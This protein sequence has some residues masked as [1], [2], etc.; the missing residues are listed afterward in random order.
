VILLTAL[1]TEPASARPDR[2]SEAETLYQRALAADLASVDG[3]RQA[4]LELEQAVLLAPDRADIQ[5]TLARLNYRMGFLKQARQRFQRVETLEPRNADARIGLGLV[6]RRDYLKYLDRGSLARA[7]E[8]FAAAAR[9]DS[10][11]CDPWLHLVPLY[12]EQANVRASL[13]VAERAHRADASRADALLGLAHAAFRN[14]QVERADSAFRRALP[15]LP[16]EVRER[17]DDIA[18]VSSEADT[19]TL[20]RLPESEQGEFVR[21]FWRE[22]DPDL[23]TTENEAQLEYW[24]RVTQAYFLFYDGRRREWDQRGEVYVRYGPPQK[25]I[26]NPVGTR[27]NFSF[28]GGPDFPMNVL[29]W[30]YPQ[31]GMN[32]SMQDRLLTEHYLRPISLV[33]DTDP[34]PD[35]DSLA[36]HQ[37]ALA[38]RGG[39]GVFPM[40]PPGARA[41]PIEGVIARFEGESGPRLM[42]LMEAPGSPGDTLWGSLVVLDSTLH[43]VARLERGLSPSLCDPAKLRVADFLTELPPGSYL[44]GLSVRDASGRRGL[45]RES[46]RLDPPRSS[47]ALSD[48]VVSCGGPQVQ[49]GDEGQPPSIRLMANPA[50]RVSGVDPLTVYFEMYHLTLAA[51][52]LAR[53]EFEYTVRS[54]ERD[55]R[56]WIQ[57]VL[58]P[59]RALPNVSA[60]RREEQAGTMRRQ[61]V[62]VPVHD[63]P[64]GRYVLEIQV[65]DLVAGTE[66]MRVASFQK[67]GG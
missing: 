19:A 47:L 6:W 3:R 57:R 41:L 25:A 11:R 7:I 64:P 36:T 56:I 52:G 21:R 4:K 63:L 37:D 29:V 5:L 49:P 28:G 45:V 18:P 8:H 22:H 10:A 43:D 2:D 48:V 12:L 44:T 9:L 26:Y 65:R 67:H 14:G 58:A 53:F 31:L 34:A 17:F 33:R 42:V 55:R 13:T 1:T 54:G 39:R 15:S 20:R 46:V 27:L 38:T 51:D 61:F 40:L 60:T 59:R 23:A 35:P 50:G 16:R 62:N 24:S 30:S 66:A 32:V